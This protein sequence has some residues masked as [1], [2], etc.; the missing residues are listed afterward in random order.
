MTRGLPTTWTTKDGRVLLIRDMEDQHV[1]NTIK[2]LRRRGYCSLAQFDSAHAALCSLQGDMSTYVAEGEFAD[3]KPTA[4]LDALTEE[5][6]RRGL[7][8][9][10]AED[11]I[12]ELL[13]DAMDD[14]KG[15][16]PR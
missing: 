15:G 14:L 2:F 6:D 16:D 11:A 13:D 5:A 12:E 3:M 10:S 1:V 7:D 9:R 8:Y 4:W